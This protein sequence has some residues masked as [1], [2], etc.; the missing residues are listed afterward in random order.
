MLIAHQ[1]KKWFA[2]PSE[3]TAVQAPRALIASLLALCLDFG[4]LILLVEDLGLHPVPA[5]V[6]A[7]LAG[8]VLQY[9]LCSLWVFPTSPASATV[10]FVAFIV[11]SLVGLGI[12]WLVMAIAC[13]MAHMPYPLAKCGALSLAFSWNFLS[14][15]YLLFRSIAPLA[16]VEETSAGLPA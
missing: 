2:D 8:S 16:T 4:M 11:L 3:S 15:K 9:I 10:G 13:D 6:L 7:Y 12:T 5:A 1:L 14:R